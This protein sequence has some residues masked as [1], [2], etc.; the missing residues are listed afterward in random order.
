[1]SLKDF[2]KVRQRDPMLN[3]GKLD[4]YLKKHAA[5]LGSKAVRSKILMNSTGLGSVAAIKQ[6]IKDHREPARQEWKTLTASSFQDFFGEQV[7]RAATPANLAQASA[8]AHGFIAT[9]VR[10]A[11]AIGSSSA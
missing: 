2:V 8:A 11:P 5:A 9:H 1:M 7:S 6:H 4:H 3:D 10:P